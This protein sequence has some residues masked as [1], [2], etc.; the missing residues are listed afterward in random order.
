MYSVELTTTDGNKVTIFFS[1]NLTV[2]QSKNTNTKE[3]ETCVMDGLH[4]N[5]GWH[6][7]ESYDNVIRA[8]KDARLS[9]SYSS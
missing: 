9:Q 5:G 8:I 7:K 3:P 6:V 4:N 2:V 1:T